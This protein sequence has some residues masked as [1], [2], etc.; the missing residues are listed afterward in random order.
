MTLPHGRYRLW[1]VLIVYLIAVKSKR[2]PFKAISVGT[3]SH[4]IRRI[5][6]FYS[7]I[8]VELSY[9]LFITYPH[10]EI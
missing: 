7:L 2:P 1:G 6:Y 9:S 5:I 10:D 8:I 3:F 4:T